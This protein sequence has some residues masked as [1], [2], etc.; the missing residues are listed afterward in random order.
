MSKGSKRRR[1]P[2]TIK[3]AR[4]Q[5]ASGAPPTI[6]YLIFFLSGAA[7][8]L[9]ELIWSRLL[10]EVFGV[11]AYATATVLATYLAGLAAGS[12]ILG[13][14]ADRHRRPL[15]F[16]GWL[17]IG[18]AAAA[19]LG[20]LI[21]PRLGAVHA[22]AAVQLAPDSLAL[23]G[24]RLALGA[25][26]IFPSTFLMGGT[27]PAMAKLFAPRTASL[28]RDLGLLYFLNTLGAVTGT[29]A[30]GFVLIGAIG[31]HATLF[32]GAGLNLAIGAVSLLLGK[33]VAEIAPPPAPVAAPRRPGRP[34]SWLLAA[35]MLA[36]IASLALEVIWTRALVLVVGSSTYAFATMLAAFLVG[37]A[38]GSWLVRLFIDRI[39]DVRA[40]FGW[41]QVGISAATL[42]AVPLLW[43]HVDWAQRWLTTLELDWR[44]LAAARFGVAFL[45]LLVPTTLIGMSFP[46]AAKLG[47]RDS[48]TVARDVGLV[49]GATSAGNILGAVI[50]GF[51]LLPV[52][53]I[54]RSIAIV[55]LL[56]LGA[57]AWGLWPAGRSERSRTLRLAPVLAMPAVIVGFLALWQP[58]PFS[59][60]LEGKDDPVLYYDEGVVSTVK[61]TQ[62]AED[63]ARQ[64]MFV[65]GVSI[66]ESSGGV[67]RKQQVLAHFPFLLH[68]GPKTV[69]STGLGSGI[70]IGEVALHPGVTSIDC[71]ELSPSVIDGA[72]AF[73]D[74][75]HGVLDDPRVRI[76]VDDGVNFLKRAPKSYDVIIAD[77]KSRMGHSENSVFYAEDYYRA[78]LDHL[79]P[80]GLFIQWTELDEI[81]EDLR[82]IVRTFVGVFPRAYLFVAQNSAYLVGSAE[83]LELDPARIQ[84]ALAAPE[85]AALWRYGWE[86]AEDV[87]AALVADQ[88]RARAWLGSETTINSFERPV[89]EFFSLRAMATPTPLRVAENFETLA[90]IAPRTS[91]L[92]YVLPGLAL[93]A[94]GEAAT[95]VGRLEQVLANFP[96][97]RMVRRWISDA[98]VELGAQLERQG[99]GGQA[100]YLYRRALAA[101]PS[102]VKG[103]VGL[104]RVLM[105]HSAIGEAA[106]HLAT[107]V[108]IKPT[109]ARAHHLLGKALLASG[110]VAGAE[111]QLQAALSLAPNDPDIHFDRALAELAADR[112]DDALTEL[113]VTMRRAPEWPA[114]M[115]QAAVILSNRSTADRDEA[116]RLARRALELSD[117]KDARV[118]EAVAAAYAGAGRWD[119]AVATQTIVN[120]LTASSG[121]RE[122]AARANAALERYRERRPARP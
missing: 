31:V 116:I 38:G 54:Q 6:V 53:G 88:V 107:A 47:A 12:W 7:G 13:R 42:A 77:G 66:G 119:D 73:A 102:S 84:L 1:N 4:D 109:S 19:L 81:P 91:S 63:P 90:A 14:A 65:D 78:A 49:Y 86:R 80:R 118:L 58:R 101:N 62:S 92:R 110:D 23:V 48:G 45:I 29:I 34:S 103:H 35:V 120:D 74:F 85:A 70:L 67:D 117:P 50:G 25:V 105:A 95:G 57:A 97:Q 96:E 43:A 44:A 64:T 17:E 10:K 51:L 2:G 60:M 113:R 94:R 106:E 37:I 24:V 61:V 112:A 41:V 98:F 114:P 18:V 87:A 104:G 71:V 39:A 22:W 89:L 28:G 111:G 21:I 68:R 46:L 40:A 69:M 115:A 99:D 76:I 83:P 3:P 55:G 33:R 26:A 100:V 11:S 16:Y 93:I 27:L 59:T 30:A 108:R 52:T 15:A 121:D 79:A 82:T 122:W 36:G 56:N 20:T 5:P 32:L 8:L 72:R 9:Y 75:N